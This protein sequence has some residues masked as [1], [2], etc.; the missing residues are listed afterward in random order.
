[1]LTKRGKGFGAEPDVDKESKGIRGEGIGGLG[2]KGL[3]KRGVRGKVER[4]LV[5]VVE[6]LCARVGRG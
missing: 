4:S 1:M 6:N 3:K 5:F 2:A